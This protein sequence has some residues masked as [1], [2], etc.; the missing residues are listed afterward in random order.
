MTLMLMMLACQGVRGR[1]GGGGAADAHDVSF[2]GI[3][4]KHAMPLMLMMLACQRVPG[5]TQC[6]SEK[7]NAADA[8]DAG[9]SGGGGVPGKTQ[10]S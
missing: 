9:L 8:H 1:Y 6:S 5:K 7:R 3:R 4:G 2:S 10:C